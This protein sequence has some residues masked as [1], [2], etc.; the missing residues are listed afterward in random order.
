VIMQRCHYMAMGVLMVAQ[1]GVAWAQNASEAPAPEPTT[2]A[3]RKTENESLLSLDNPNDEPPAA[4]STNGSG[5]FLFWP[6]PAPLDGSLSTDR[7]GFADTTSV[8]P[9]GHLQLELGY[10]Y[11]EDSE[12]GTRTRDHSFAQTNLR[13]GVLDNL[14]FRTI[15]S[16]FSATESQFVAES[17]R[18]GRRYRTTDHDD[19]AGD[20]TLGLRTQ[21]LENDGLVP[22]LT[23]LTNLSIPVGSQGKTAGD[24]VPDVRLA[25]GWALTEKSRLYGVGIASAP[26]SEGDRFFQAAGS[27]GLSYAWTNRFSTFAEYYGIFP[28][29]K[30]ADCSHNLDGGFAFLLSDNCQLDFSAGLGL[31]EQAPDYFVGV[32][33]SFRW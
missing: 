30:D 2:E 3:T 8:M 16:G 23:L 9:R 31:N 1:C 20:M 24:V 12:G 17:P 28:G 18:T 11:T 33:I 5:G 32:G 27:A 26:T 14:E 4:A 6:S 13:I 15:W 25:Y 7:P 21:L 29:A 19:G 10:T 22:D